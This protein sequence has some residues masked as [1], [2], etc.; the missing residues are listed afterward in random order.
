MD[1]SISPWL[2][3]APLTALNKKSGGICL[4]AI[5]EVIRRLVSGICCTAVKARLQE[6][7]LPYGQFGVGVRGG[8]EAAIRTL[9]SYI[10]TNSLRKNLCCFKIDMRI[11]FNE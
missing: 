2:S 9:K 7:I 6:V 4:F 8:L 5:G 3:G 11:A 10:T 1:I